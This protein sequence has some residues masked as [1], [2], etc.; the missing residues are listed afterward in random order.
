M[1]NSAVVGHVHPRSRTCRRRRRAAI[2]HLRFWGGGVGWMALRV[3][4]WLGVAAVLACAVLAKEADGDVLVLT[5]SSFDDALKDH[6]NVLVEFYA[7]WCGHCKALAPEYEKAATHLKKDKVGAKLAKVDCTEEKEVCE[8]YKVQGYPTL[9]WFSD[10][11]ARE[12]DGGRKAD[13]IAGYVKRFSGPAVV[14]LASAEDVAKFTKDVGIKA[15]AFLKKDSKHR[16][17]VDKVAEKLRADVSFAV[18]P[19]KVVGEVDAE[20]A[21]AEAPVFLIFLPFAESPVRYTGN[22]FDKSSL[23]EFIKAESFPLV[24][25]ISPENYKSY[26]DRG[27]PLV[28]AF[29]DKSGRDDHIAVLKEAAKE[30]K[31]K[32]SWVWLDAVDYAR[33]AENMGLSDKWPGVVIDDQANKKKYL[34]PEDSSFAAGDLSSWAQKVLDGDVAP[35]VKSEEV[36]EDNSGPLT[37]IVGKNYDEIVLDDSKDVLLEF[38]APWCGHCQQ[39]APKYKTLADMFADDKSVVIAQVDGTQNDIP[40]EIQGFPTIFFFPAGKKSNPLT[41]QGERSVAAIAKFIADKS[42][43]LS[44]D[45]KKAVSSLSDDGAEDE[46]EPSGD[47]DEDKEEL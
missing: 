5:T 15:V 6:K 46:E 37:K 40:L 32:L 34:Y 19:Y 7:P 38:Y 28:W 27:L 33:H 21:K 3:V 4:A 13:A 35:F 29:L 17:V 44:A 16:A 8:R 24:A 22:A 39:L 42:T 45:R 31:G 1:C 25:E 18:A 20:S 30:S 23:E 36:P 41:Y 10:G 26:V 12:Y 14:D 43:T 47:D 2:F 11:V 9:K